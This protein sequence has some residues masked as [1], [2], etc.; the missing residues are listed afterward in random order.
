[1]VLECATVSADTIQV[2]ALVPTEPNADVGR[3]YY[4]EEVIMIVLCAWC[5]QEGTEALIRDTAG[6]VGLTSHGIC[7]GHEK[8]LLK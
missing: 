8:R 2:Q 3:L 6:N 1:V 7:E 5:E 4:G